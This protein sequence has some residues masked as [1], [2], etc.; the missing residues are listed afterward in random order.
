[1]IIK[2]DPFADRESK[3]YDSPIVSR[4]FIL[5]KIS[6]KKFG[7]TFNQILNTFNISSVED[8]KALMR[9]LKAMVRDRQIERNYKGKYVGYQPKK[10]KSKSEQQLTRHVVGTIIK[11]RNDYR[12]VVANKEF[13]SDLCIINVP[14][15]NNF[16]D[17]IVHATL[18][19]NKSG[20]YAKYVDLLG[21][22]NSKG[23]EAK[24][25]ILEYELPS[26]FPKKVIKQADEFSEPTLPEN[27]QDLTSID[28]VTIDGED[29][30][31]YDDAVY[32]EYIAG[33]YHLYVA[34][35]DVSHYVELNSALDQEAKNRGTSVY[36]P[37]KVVPMLPE[38]LSNELCSL[39]PGKN[40][41]ALVCKI[42]FNGTGMVVKSEFF[43]AMIRSKARLTYTKV[44]DYL[45][46]N[47]RVSFS[48]NIKKSLDLLY[49][50][51]GLLQQHRRNRGAL[52]LD[53]TDSSLSFDSNGKISEVKVG[54][55]NIAHIL[56]E[57][58]MLSANV[59]AAELLLKHK[60]PALY[61]NHASPLPDKILE[62]DRFLM[63]FDMQIPGSKEDLK[64]KQYAELLSA[65]STVPENRFIQTYMLR[66]LMQAYYD[67]DNI[68]HFGL[69][70]QHYCHFTS[71]IRRYPDLVV[72]RQIKQI[73]N[74]LPS[75]YKLNEV[76]ELGQECSLLERRAE[77]ASRECVQWLKCHYMQ[78]YIGKE[79]TG[80]ISSVV[81]F[82]FFVE[83]DELL[84][85]GL[86]HITT[87]IDDYYDI[88]H[89]TQSLVG[90]KTNKTYS[91]GRKCSIIVSKVDVLLGRID[92]EL[93]P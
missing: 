30:R 17:S 61:R 90:E 12:L 27:Y 28:F 66:T 89:M 10:K 63:N 36:F 52:E 32:G 16:S 19:K 21:D 54:K 3:K 74:G 7:L 88:D 70:Y 79:F 56:I 47:N 41:L 37:G 59:C 22:L 92:F 35:A 1:M 53:L 20:L 64:P 81:K 83:L 65:L 29:A 18:H 14:E 82:G 4:E 11:K 26:I 73:I 8:K 62:L 42:S 78:K 33:N 34:I 24:A 76:E 49:K 31:D 9:R 5:D 25:K 68:G 67:P 69:A 46:D 85:E 71:P 48:N 80:T 23:I 86:V 55:R 60:Y 50:L 40:R 38:N 72:H 15:K 93:V 43:N 91:L 87:L 58:C 6:E 84:V 39:V 57:E 45:E 44:A 2:K 77:S 75:L 13:A 51:C